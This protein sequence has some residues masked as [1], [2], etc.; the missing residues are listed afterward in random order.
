MTVQASDITCQTVLPSLFLTVIESNWMSLLTRPLELS[1]V[2]F[3][4]FLSLT[5]FGL[6]CRKQHVRTRIYDKVS[7]A[8]RGLTNA[9]QDHTMVMLLEKM[10]HKNPHVLSICVYYLAIFSITLVMPLSC[11]FH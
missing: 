9:H 2:F 6:R 3:N 10:F 1:S 11:F 7:S 5:F 4:K 8:N